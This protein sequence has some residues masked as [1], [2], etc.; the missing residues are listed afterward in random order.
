M[1]SLK[2]RIKIQTDAV[3]DFKGETVF[4]PG[5]HDWYSGLKGLK[6]QEKIVEDQLGKDTFLPEKWLSY[7]QSSCF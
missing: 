7:K 4:L 6:R 1:N 2:H 3:K 5:N